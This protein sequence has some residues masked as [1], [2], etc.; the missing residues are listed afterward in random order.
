MLIPFFLFCVGVALLLKGADYFVEGG[1]GLARRFGVSQIT[2]GFTVIAFGT[3]LPEF[4]VSIHAILIDS[5][6][7]ALGNVVGSN[8]ANIALVLALCA[9]INP[10]VLGWETFS[11]FVRRE[12]IF[13]LGA[14]ALFVLL[15]LRGSFD[16]V[17]GVIFLVAFFMI[18]HKLW[19]NGRIE[20]EEISSH[21]SLDYLYTL[22]GL[23]AV[24]IGSVLVID[25]A[26]IIAELFGIPAF[27][28]GL[29][30]VAV[31][32]SLPELA[33][34]LVAIMKGRGG[35]SVG[36]IIGSNI[37]NLLFVIGCGSLIRPIIVP[38]IFDILIMGAFSVCALAFFT[39]SDQFTR[40]WALVLIS[41]YGIYIAALFGVI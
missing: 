5:P 41:L 3:S 11:R 6:D 16:A 34:S 27:V 10:A 1:G 38:E 37:F 26:I 8:I 2:I 31:G 25:N 14:T 28:I 36:N 32:T 40:G 13:M 20:S 19:T 4:V 33:T 29:S 35:I 7:V 22:G 24:I 21:G 18:L 12:T 30:I 23:I 9:L 39:R 15:A 17:S